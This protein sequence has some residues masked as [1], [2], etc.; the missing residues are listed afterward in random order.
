M[1]PTNKCT[2]CPAPATGIGLC[3]ACIIELTHRVAASEPDPCTIPC[4]VC[5]S[6]IQFTEA[7][8]IRY[9]KDPLRGNQQTPKLCWVCARLHLSAHDPDTL[10]PLAFI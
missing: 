3:N 6:P 2:Q 9:A 5:E 10:P 4:A 8:V 7:R 1:S